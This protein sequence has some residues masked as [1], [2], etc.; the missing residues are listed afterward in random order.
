MPAKESVLGSHFTSYHNPKHEPKPRN[1]RGRFR[2]APNIAVA[3]DRLTTQTAWDR[4]GA[5]LGD[6][7]A[8]EQGL[9]PGDRSWHVLTQTDSELR[10][11]GW[12]GGR[13]SKLAS[14]PQNG[15]CKWKHG[16][17]LVVDIHFNPYPVG[18]S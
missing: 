6:G 13:G 7:G 17:K 5:W 3:S 18:G 4:L 1:L 16:L 9:A 15:P 11:L 14:T 2:E 8:E 10:Q 12:R